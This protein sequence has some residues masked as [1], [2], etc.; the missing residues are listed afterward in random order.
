MDAMMAAKGGKKLAVIC[1]FDVRVLEAGIVHAFAR[2]EHDRTFALLTMGVEEITDLVSLL[3]DAAKEANM[4][5][6]A[7]SGEDFKT[8]GVA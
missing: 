1:A 7:E 3:L 4:L 6:A 2:D 5:R 8:E